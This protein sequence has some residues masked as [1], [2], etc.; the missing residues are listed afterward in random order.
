MVALKRDERDTPV[1]RQTLCVCPC[2]ALQGIAFGIEH[3]RDEG[4]LRRQAVCCKI[5][6]DEIAIIADRQ[7]AAIVAQVE[8]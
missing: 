6:P 3:A 5:D 8:P 2:L 1:Q 7:E 4:A